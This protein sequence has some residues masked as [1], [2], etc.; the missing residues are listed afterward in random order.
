ML[1][2]LVVGQAADAGIVRTVAERATEPGMIGWTVFLGS[3]LVLVAISKIASTIRA[4]SREKTRREIAAYVAEG[5]LTPEQGERLMRA[6][7]FDGAGRC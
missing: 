4:V 5:S 3:L 7:P 6:G 2:L 1:D